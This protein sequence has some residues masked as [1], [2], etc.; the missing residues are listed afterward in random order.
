MSNEVL[1]SQY[2]HSSRLFQLAD[3]LTMSRPQHMLLKNLHGSSPAFVIAAIFNLPTTSQLNHIVI[4]EDAETAAYFHNSLENLTA[5]LDIFYFPSSFKNNKTW[6]ELNNSHVMLRTE[7]LTRWSGGGNKKII[8]TYPEALFEKV[9]LPETLAGNMIRLKSGETIR[10]EQMMES[11]VGFGFERTD[12]VY[13]PGQ[14]A[15]RGGILDIYSFGNEKPYRVELFGNEVDSIRIFDPE[16]QLSERRLLQVNIIPNI[17]THFA[18]EK[19]I[20]LFEFLPENTVVWMQDQRFIRDRLLILEKELQDFL[21]SGSHKSIETA[22]GGL[23]RI[24]TKDDFIQPYQYRNPGGKN[25][26]C[27]ICPGLTETMLL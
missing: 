11:L 17:E 8:V 22:E 15:L 2:Q 23:G 21:A 4:C 26:P 25:A 14:F 5:A 18:D 6:Q 9:V 13:E 27:R 24:L 10:L 3:R 20:S 12:F 19:K 16:S 7:A 1:L